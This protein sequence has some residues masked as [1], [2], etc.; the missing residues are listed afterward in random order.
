MPWSERQR[1]ML[2]AMGVRLFDAIRSSQ[3]P[4]PAAVPT[5]AATATATATATPPPATPAATAKPA[6]RQIQAPAAAPAPATSSRARPDVAAL[7]WPEL[8]AAVADC[9]AC[10]LAESRQQTVFGVGHARAH[11]MVIGEAPGEQED[12]Q[13]EPFVG[14]SGQLLDNI[15][16]KSTR[17]N[18]SH[19]KLSRMPSSA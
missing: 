12:R 19:G 10:A 17:L 8:R 14:K 18:S 13:G 2:R 6:P 15:D 4:A 11:W 5:A 9:R 3:A 16:R 7:G 1:D